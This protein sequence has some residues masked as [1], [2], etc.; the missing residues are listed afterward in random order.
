[1]NL[2]PNIT[3][4]LESL[5]MVLSVLKLLLPLTA[6]TRVKVF[7]G[8]N[9]AGSGTGVSGMR[10]AVLSPMLG[11]VRRLTASESGVLAP[12]PAAAFATGVA[13]STADGV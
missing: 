8:N 3:L 10:R 11:R 7:L 13:V 2:V 4:V 6:N 12:P 5:M 1:M 9:R